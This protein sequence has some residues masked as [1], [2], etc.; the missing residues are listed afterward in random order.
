M[1]RKTFVKSAS[2]LSVLA[3][4]GHLPACTSE[5][6]PVPD[7]PFEIDLSQSP[8]D[9]LTVENAW[10]LHPTANV[11][12]INDNGLIRAFTSICTHSGCSRQWAFNTNFVC[13][14]HGS[15]F[16]TSGQVVKGPANRNLAELGTSF[17]NGI[18]TIN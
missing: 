15:E 9:Q 3:L 4:L 7:G 5:Q 1:N 13:Q 11:L 2:S 16:N 17:E 6:E 10:L 18:V 8:F 14:C 12:L